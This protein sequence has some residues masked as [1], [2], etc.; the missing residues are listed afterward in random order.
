MKTR[1]YLKRLAQTAAKRLQRFGVPI[2]RIQIRL[3]GDCQQRNGRD[4]QCVLSVRGQNDF[5][6]N[7]KQQ[8]KTFR[9]AINASF[10]RI[11]QALRRQH[12]KHA[13]SASAAFDVS[14]YAGNG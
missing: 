7:V 1:T 14:S 12:S 9:Q 13:A 4:K 3:E 11:E 2:N 10:H 8:G 5:S 6:L